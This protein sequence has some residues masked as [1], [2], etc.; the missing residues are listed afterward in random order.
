MKFEITILGSGSSTPSLRRNPAAQLINIMENY[1]LVDCGEGTQIQMRKYK[2]K[3]Q[4]ID[5]IF[6]S[7]LHGD[8]YLGLI[9]ML[10]SMHLLGRKK[11][12]HLYAHPDLKEMIDLHMKISQTRLT[13]SIVFHP[14]SYDASKVIFENKY[15]TVSTVV[16]KHR[17]PCCG[18]V[19]K[20]KEKQ[21]PLDTQS[22]KALNVPMYAFNALKR[23][24]DVKL[25]DGRTIA[26]KEVTFHRPK[27][28]SYAYCSDTAY[29]EKII[30][31]IKGVDV[32][33]HESTFTE[34]LNDR[35]KETHHSTAR[36]AATIAQKAEVGK[37]VLGH[38][39]VRY[40]STENFLAEAS[41]VFPNTIAAEDGMVIRVY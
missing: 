2:V 11:N 24:E 40:K 19:F 10:Q 25:E 28:Y 33:F 26:F 4:K 27:S 7:H 17:I 37:L 32:L 5:H 12:V 39:S 15:I 38:F 30:E 41:A 35:A 6:I 29:L 36:Q 23:G 31:S 1:F 13:F 14:L 16:L 9:G 8:H 3:F 21:Y 20:E 22:A 18:F 34:E